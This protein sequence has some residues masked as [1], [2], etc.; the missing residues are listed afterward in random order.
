MK[1]IKKYFLL[2]FTTLAIQ[3]NNADA[4]LSVSLS[5]YQPV[6]NHDGIVVATVLNG[7]PPYTYTWNGSGING[8]IHNSSLTTDTIYNFSGGYIGVTLQDAIGTFASN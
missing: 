7:T 6:C 5:T 1:T 8:V 2:A 3:L 4:Q